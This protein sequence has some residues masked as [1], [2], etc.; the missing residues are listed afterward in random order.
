[1]CTLLGY[2][3]LNFGSQYITTHVHIRYTKI[4]SV[5]RTVYIILVSGRQ[6]NFLT[7]MTPNNDIVIHSMSGTQTLGANKSIIV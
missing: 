3:K 5:I 2:F 1:M 4:Q 6:Q 7:S